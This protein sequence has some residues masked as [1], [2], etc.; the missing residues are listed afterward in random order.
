MG[1]QTRKNN[2]VSKIIVDILE[3]DHIKFKTILRARGFT[4]KYGV[5]NL[6]KQFNLGK[7][8]IDP[9]I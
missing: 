8:K 1:F 7:I 3:Q 5:Y 9:S 4:I 2:Q 6:I